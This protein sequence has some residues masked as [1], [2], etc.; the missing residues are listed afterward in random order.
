MAYLMR[1]LT[2]TSSSAA[3]PVAPVALHQPQK[4][5]GVAAVAAMPT[6][7]DKVEE[8][9]YETEEEEEEEEK[10]GTAAVA[11]RKDGGTGSSGAGRQREE[12]LVMTV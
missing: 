3:A 1:R 5:E 9:V 2:L 4:E 12:S 11:L 8:G 7:V 6:V 10:D